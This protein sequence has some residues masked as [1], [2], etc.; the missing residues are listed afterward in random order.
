MA[1]INESLQYDDDEQTL[2][3]M[4]MICGETNVN[5]LLLNNPKL[6]QFVE[7]ERQNFDSWDDLEG[8]RGKQQ[9]EETQKDSLFCK[10]GGMQSWMT[11]SG[12]ILSLHEHVHL[13]TPTA[14]IL[15]L[16]DALLSTELHQE[17]AMNTPNIYPFSSFI[18]IINGP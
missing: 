17:Y 4:E 15:S 12:F 7:K 5:P 9:V 2:T 3:N 11:H 1:K 16:F 13:E 10:T 14:V 6:A 18:I 8:C